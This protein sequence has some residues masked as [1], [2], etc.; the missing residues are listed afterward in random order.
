V[1]FFASTPTSVGADH[2]PS[3]GVHQLTAGFGAHT[4]S[5]LLVR[6]CPPVVSLFDFLL[7][8]VDKDQ[9]FSPYSHAFS[10]LLP[11]AVVEI[12]ECWLRRR[13]VARIFSFFPKPFVLLSPRLSNTVSC[14]HSIVVHV[15][16]LSD[17]CLAPPAS[18]RPPCLSEVTAMTEG[19]L[20]R[21]D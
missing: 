2:I 13:G 12:L 6:P 4:H 3:D 15:G 14:L 20:G 16:P 11:P 8:W 18:A 10:S 7:L 1:L 17:I 5:A 19:F 21:T 9:Y